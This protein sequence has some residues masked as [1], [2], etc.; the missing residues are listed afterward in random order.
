MCASPRLCARMGELLALAPWAYFARAERLRVVARAASARVAAVDIGLAHQA[1]ADQ[2]GRDA[3]RGKPGEIGGRIEAALADHD[4][5]ARN[6][7]QAAR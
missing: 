3:D 4:A 1:F 6:A 2:E 7:A 5:L